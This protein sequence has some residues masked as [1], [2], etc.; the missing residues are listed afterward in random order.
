VGRGNTVPVAQRAGRHADGWIPWQID[1]GVFASHARA[2]HDAYR[3]SGRTGRFTVVAPLAAGRV[4]HAAA[5]G[6]GIA[7]WRA[8]G[9]SAFHVGFRHRSCADMIELLERF[10]TTWSRRSSDL[11]RRRTIKANSDEKVGRQYRAPGTAGGPPA[12]T[13][14]RY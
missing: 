2:A 11:P 3:Q 10:A 14:V 12:A 9:A 5:L 6:D 1:L 7:A 4:E 13:K 8:A